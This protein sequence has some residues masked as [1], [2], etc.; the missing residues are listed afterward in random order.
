ML[1]LGD[2]MIALLMVFGVLI[3]ELFDLADLLSALLIVSGISTTKKLKLK[4]C[5][6][7]D[8]IVY[9]F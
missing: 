9:F 6:R 3:V 1:G 7:T 8:I 2:Q 5:K 4:T